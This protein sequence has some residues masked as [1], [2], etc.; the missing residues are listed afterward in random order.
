[1]PAGSAF[2][3]KQSD[4]IRHAVTTAHDE[5]G[6]HFFVQVGLVDGD[7][8]AY[9]LRRHAALGAVAEF[10]VFVL[11]EPEARR[12]EIVTGE[13]AARRLDDRA[14]GLASLAMATSFAGGD[15]TGG[16]VNGV[17]MMAQAAARP[18]VLHEHEAD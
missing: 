14:A 18:P 5:T 1:M 16:V 7:I 13:T 11:V 8:R 4:Q 12:V 3:S 6:L 17:R 10:G 15:L 9:A 2:T